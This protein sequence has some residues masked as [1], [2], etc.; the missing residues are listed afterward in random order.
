[1]S[2]PIY[3]EA[4]LNGPWSKERQPLMPVTIDDLIA[5]GIDCAKAGVHVITTPLH[6]LLDLLPHPLTDK[7]L[8]T[9]LKDY[10][11]IR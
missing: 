9:F 1:M 10:S 11:T 8:Q 3:I 6:A 4:A 5:E 2:R 7:G